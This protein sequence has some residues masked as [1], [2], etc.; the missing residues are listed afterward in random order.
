[1]RREPDSPVLIQKKRYFF[2]L[3]D[4]TWAASDTPGA[5]CVK[6]PTKEYGNLNK[7]KKIVEAIILPWPIVIKN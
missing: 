4:I 6:Q 3:R 2:R 5:E 7:N 1:M